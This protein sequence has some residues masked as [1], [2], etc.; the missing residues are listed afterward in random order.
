[1]GH[2]VH[3][4]LMEN[5]NAMVSI[6]AGWAISALRDDSQTKWRNFKVENGDILT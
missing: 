6:L 4:Q 3:F 2:L 5:T 1:M